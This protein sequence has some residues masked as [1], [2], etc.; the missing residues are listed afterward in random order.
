QQQT[1][2]RY[3]NVTPFFGYGGPGY[4]VQPHRLGEVYMEGRVEAI[5]FDIVQFIFIFGE[6]N[7]NI[8]CI[9]L[10]LDG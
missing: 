3:A 2:N 10:S 7:R 1:E 9:S 8:L 4:G 6:E 5:S